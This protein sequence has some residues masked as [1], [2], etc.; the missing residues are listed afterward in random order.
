MQRGS[1]PRL[2]AFVLFIATACTAV[3]QMPPCFT[4]DGV[5]FDLR[6]NGQPVAALEDRSVLEQYEAGADPATKTDLSRVQWQIEEPISGPIQIQAVYNALGTGW[7]GEQAL[8]DVL[9]TPLEGQDLRSRPELETSSEVDDEGRAVQ[10]EAD[11]LQDNK[12][13]PGAYLFKVT[14]RGSENWDR[15]YILVIAE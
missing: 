6:I 2:F 4:R 7:F 5:C 9:V 13:P 3:T 12:L 1:V 11:V 10:R 8:P 15:K 14:L